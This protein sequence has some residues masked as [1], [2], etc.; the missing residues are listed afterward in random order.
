MSKTYLLT[1]YTT[2]NVLQFEVESALP[3]FVD[4]LAEAMESGSVTLDTTDRHTL[5]LSLINAVALEI[6]EIESK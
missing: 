4:S 5:V 1:V 3:N 2:D 6:A